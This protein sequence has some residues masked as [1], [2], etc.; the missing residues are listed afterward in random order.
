MITGKNIYLLDCSV[1][2]SGIY[3]ILKVSFN[4][5]DCYEMPYMWHFI[6][7]KTVSDINAETH[8]FKIMRSLACN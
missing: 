7:T 2:N 5:D 8:Y 1:G 6:I 4:P 3:R